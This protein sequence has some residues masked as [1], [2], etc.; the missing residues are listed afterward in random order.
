MLYRFNLDFSDIDRGVYET[1]DFRVMQHPSESVPYLLTRVLAFALSH[2]EGLEFSPAG[3]GDPELPAIRLFGA[4]GVVDL[5]IEIGNPSAR[6]LHKAAKTAKKVVVYT[7]KSPEVLLKDIADNDV[8][9]ANEIEVY[10]FDPKFLLELESLL[11]K[12]NRWSVLHQQGRLD[13]ESGGTSVSGDVSSLKV[14]KN[15]GTP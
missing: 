9:R 10:A 7:Y 1:L 3:L 4:H 11:G 6:K 13:I 14:A 15:P 5:W 12:S 8:H 2:Q